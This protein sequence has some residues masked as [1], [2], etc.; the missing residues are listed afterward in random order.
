MPV[1]NWIMAASHQSEVPIIFALASIALLVTL[2]S[3]AGLF[4]LLFAKLDKT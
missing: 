2:P 3:L 4:W 1:W